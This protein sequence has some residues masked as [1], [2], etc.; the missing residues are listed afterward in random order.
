ML[1][2][3]RVALKNVDLMLCEITRSIIAVRQNAATQRVS[4]NTEYTRLPTH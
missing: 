2:A 4:R 3:L 1:G